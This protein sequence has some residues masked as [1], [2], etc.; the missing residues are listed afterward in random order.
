MKKKRRETK[1]ERGFSMIELIVAVG[2]V[3]MVL[4]TITGGVSVAV[5]NSR[6][7]K[8]KSLSVRYAQE[9]I[10][11]L[12]KNREVV[13]WNA[14][15]QIVKADN[16]NP[17][18]YCITDTDGGVEDFQDLDNVSE[19]GVNQ[20]IDGTIFKRLVTIELISEGCVGCENK[21][22]LEVVVSWNDGSQE[23]QS[24]LT[25]SLYEW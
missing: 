16:N 18:S 9:A 20:Q 5:R 17:V 25:T 4:V 11:W 3:V 2:V 6:F 1:M 23:L 24:K 8:E 22:E 14:F 10:E 21:M 13:G 15:R 12:R 19:C 7:S